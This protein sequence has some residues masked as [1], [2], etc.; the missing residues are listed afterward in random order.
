M[1]KISKTAELWFCPGFSRAKKRGYFFKKVSGYPPAK[2]FNE[3]NV[4]KNQQEVLKK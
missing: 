3:R 2:T 4:L 1:P